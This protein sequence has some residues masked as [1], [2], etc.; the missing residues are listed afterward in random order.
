MVDKNRPPEQTTDADSGQEAPV[1]IVG[2]LKSGT[3]LLL[4][5]LDSHPDLFAIPVE[6]KFFKATSVPTLP[7]GNGPFD[8]S[9]VRDIPFDHPPPQT[10]VET[11][12]E[13]LMSN[14][15]LRAALN[16]G[17]LP[18]NIELP[19]STLSKK[20]F[21]HEIFQVSGNDD[22]AG[23]LDR[24]MRAF[25]IAHSKESPDSDPKRILEKTPHNEEFAWLLKQ[26]FPNA[27][28]LHL[29]RNPYANIH[30]L[31]SKDWRRRN[32][33]RTYY[34]FLAK[35][36]YFLE[37]NRRDIDDYHVVKF[38]D[39]VLHTEATMR[40][41]SEVLGV[42][43]AE[44]MLEPTYWGRPWGGNSRSVDESFTGVD[45]RPASA[46]KDD[47]SDLHIR[48]VNRF[49]GSILEKYDYQRLTP[50]RYGFWIPDKIED[51]VNY[52]LNRTLVYDTHP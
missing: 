6:L 20:A 23:L 18:R 29:L 41:V 36:L 38:E 15:E 27:T 34:R 19:T 22:L 11:V 30:S 47:V 50:S 43:F 46:F 8:P 13:E 44:S 35:S 42:P 2:N 26:W 17:R 39:L 16:T 4:S 28:F 3:S 48:L 10:D 9:A 5:L 40:T 7:P 24:A 33:R 14:P 51:P 21:Q 49:F 12:A 52:I 37:R 45:P 1:F 25:R 32:V 31:E